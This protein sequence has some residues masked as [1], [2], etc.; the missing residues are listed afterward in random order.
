[1]P[2]LFDMKLRALRRE[3]AA[4]EGP[5]L[6]LA[7]RL[8]NDCLDR[9]S[10]IKRKFERGLLI[11]CPDP[12]WPGRLRAFAGHVDVRDP[13]IS[14]AA[15]A[16]GAPIVEDEWEPPAQAYD[17]VLAI[18]TLDT[19]NDLAL[20][21]R[22]L[23]YSMKPDGLLIGVLAGG[24]TL[25]QLRSA[26]RAADLVRGIAA[27]H[28]H[29]R[30]EA[31]ALSPL[32]ANQGFKGPVVDVE[33]VQLSYPSLERL[34]RDLRHMAATNILCSKPPSL[35]RTQRD[36]AVR[37]FADAGDDGRT[38]EIFELLHFAAWTPP[39]G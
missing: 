39:K 13:G 17:L 22:L 25:R 3:R 29:P 5:E 10:L 15:R 14:F 6:F 28:I 19:I 33:R 11:G 34:V 8:F 18:G 1:V 35:T 37:A 20:A 36:A 16:H 38:I 32:L 26:M 23:F 4:R 27:A 30:I 24:D 7:E 21:F 2:K 31:S 9:I 12:G